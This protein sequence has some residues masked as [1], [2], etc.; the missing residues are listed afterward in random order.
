MIWRLIAIIGALT[1][2]V[3]GSVI[4]TDD[5]CKSVDISGGRVLRFACYESAHRGNMSQTE[6][7]AMAIGIGAAIPLLLLLPTILRISRERRE[8]IRAFRINQHLQATRMLFLRAVAQILATI[9]R[10]E[11]PKSKEW[12]LSRRILISFSDDQLTDPEADRLLSDARTEDLRASLFDEEQRL[13]LL[14]L[15]VD[16][17]AVNGNISEAE[18]SELVV[19][20]A[21]LAFPSHVLDSIIHLVLQGMASE[22]Q[23]SR[24]QDACAILG[25]EPSAQI[26]EIRAAYRSLMMLHHPDRASPDKRAEATRKSAE[27]NAAYDLLIGRSHL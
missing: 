5:T 1:F 11:G 13:L 24:L 26:G 7:A 27:I 23:P 18:R 21:R 17:A 22:A 3:N 8:R 16:I 12:G 4:L 14:R 2:V 6:A 25:V 9:A 20:A 15:A 10:V 19:L